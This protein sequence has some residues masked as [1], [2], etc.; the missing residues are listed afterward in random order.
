MVKTKNSPRINAYR[1]HILTLLRPL[2][3]QHVPFG[4]ALD[5]GSGDGLF[6]KVFGDEQI[7]DEV[8]PVDVQYRKMCWVEPVLYDG[9]RL[10]F[11][12]R[13][14]ELVYAMDVLHHCDDPRTSIAEMARCSSKYVLIKDHTY[15]KPIGKLTLCLLDEIGNRRFGVPSLYNYQ[16]GREWSPWLEEEGFVL[17]K[18]I[19]PAACHFSLVGKFLNRLEFIALWMRERT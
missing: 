3:E 2:L 5:Y 16:R 17:E 11:D 18:V 15:Q 12:D 8:V 10:P 19:H 14:F 4:R 7:A 13:S 1:R 6:A 9:K